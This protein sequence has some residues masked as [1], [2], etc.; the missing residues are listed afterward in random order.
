MYMHIGGSGSEAELARGVQAVLDTVAELRGGNPS[1]APARNVENTLDIA[2]IDE[3]L[4]YTGELNRGVYKLT[5]GRPDVS[6]TSSGARVTT[7]MGFNTWAA[8]QGTPDDAAVAGDFT[9]LESEVAPVIEALVDNGIEVVAVH[10]H[11]VHEEPQVF[12]LHYWG[13]GPADELARGLRAALD[14]T[15]HAG[16]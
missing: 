4:G 1:S 6:V 5:I 10:N 8:W 9:M 15:G 11:M 2:Q 14:E 12:F 16:D 3:L 7:F 13:T